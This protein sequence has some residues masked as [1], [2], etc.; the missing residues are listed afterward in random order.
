[1]SSPDTRSVPRWIA[2]A[3]PPVAY[4]LVASQYFA[5]FLAHPHRG[6][7]GG[8]D[9]ILY[10]WYFEWVHQAVVHLHNPLFSPAMNAPYGLNIMWNTALL[11][12]AVVCVPLT[13]T[14]GP[15]AT[16]GLLMVAAP[17]L[18]ASTCY[19][20]LRHITRRA[21]PS[22]LAAALYG[23]G[24]FFVG[25]QGHLHLSFA[26][27]PPLLLLFG[28]RLLVEK[29]PHVIRTGLWFGVVLALQMLI[30][31]EVVVLCAVVTVVS[32]A[33]LALLHR[34][35]A[36]ARVRQVATASGVAIGVALVLAGGP[37]AYQFFGAQALRHGIGFKPERVDLAGLVRPSVLQFFATEGDIRANS[38]FPAN[39]VENTGYLG[40]PLVLLLLGLGVWAVRR[41]DRAL[42]W[43]LVSI[44]VAVLFSLG[45]RITVNGASLGPGP[46]AALQRLPLLGGVVAPRFSL[47]TTLL[48]ALVLAW[49]LAG[50]GGRALALGLA[51]FTL[52]VLPLLPSGRYDEIS[53]VHTPRFFRTAAVRTIPSGATAYVMPYSGR[54]ADAAA[55][56]MFWQ[57][58][59]H[60]RFRIVGGYSVFNRDGE[61]AYTGVEPAYTALLNSAGRSGKVPS[62]SALAAARPS[63][64]SSGTRYIV[65]TRNVR[66]PG[67]AGTAARTLTGCTL[68]TVED[69]VLCAIPA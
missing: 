57:L 35:E 29:S 11:A 60:L 40:W 23:F 37:L 31:E 56:V 28:H 42:G 66:H 24:P 53:V 20:V 54:S 22:A 46:W 48:V 61:L 44:A 59:A 67:A 12:L 19:F 38:G 6:V 10:A 41:R 9:G 21:L 17:V 3:A 25:Q 27:F 39:A 50:L 18:S 68:R 55:Q 36:R 8:A 7:P 15:I 13:A 64:R 47:L 49:W 69:V 2:L 52:A 30:A 5:H 45:H 1:M 26:V 34:D 51:A 65:I 63:V 58:R 14:I 33:V 4:A 32:V 62:A 43:G 16:V